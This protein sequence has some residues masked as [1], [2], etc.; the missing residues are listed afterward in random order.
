[1]KVNHLR[2]VF[3]WDSVPRLGFINR[4]SDGG[5]QI[6]HSYSAH[7]LPVFLLHRGHRNEGDFCQMLGTKLTTQQIANRGGKEMV[8]VLEDLLF[9]LQFLLVGSMLGECARRKMQE[10]SLMV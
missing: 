7:S 3:N 8:H 9:S 1:M 2:S 4:P 5:R 6:P 10:D